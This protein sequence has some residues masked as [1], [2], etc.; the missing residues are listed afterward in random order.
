MKKPVK[1][2]YS[3]YCGM[4]VA[5]DTVVV[6]VAP[7]KE[8]VIKPFTITQDEKGFRQLRKT[9]EHDGIQPSSI[10][11]V[12][13]PTG[14]YYLPVARFLFR[15]GYDVVI[16]NSLTARRHIQAMLEQNKTDRLDAL[17]LANMGLLVRDKLTL[18]EEPPRVY[19]E[20]RQR[21]DL[22]DA[23]VDV[24]KKQLVRQH[25]AQSRLRIEAVDR[26]RCEVIE[27]I[28]DKIKSLE[29]EMKTILLADPDWGQT[30]R[31]LLSITGFGVYI[32]TALIVHTLNFTTMENA[33]QL[34][35]FVGVVPR[36]HESG[37]TRYAY[38]GFSSIPR[39]R[40]AL[41]MCTMSAVRYNP[42]L[43]AYYNRLVGRG[44]SRQKTRIAC[45]RKLL[46][47]AWGCVRNQAMFDPE[48]ANKARSAKLF[49]GVA[50]Q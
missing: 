48:Y 43:Q 47:I 14:T 1:P 11:V 42:V 44:K 38:I 15:A 46:H 28:D 31:Y 29:K 36:K 41:Y 33:D 6:A 9:L 2:S 35:S 24:R 25:A 5:K 17:H 13:E 30:A 18:W 32:V 49:D 7:S 23:L 45:I 4:D 8:C 22:R 34:S 39:L 3:L 26:Q 50:I 10:L 21:L 37:Q 19:E 20:L 12:I 40:Q 16:I 27:Y